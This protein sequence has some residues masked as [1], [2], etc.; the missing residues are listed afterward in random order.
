MTI[1]KISSN[2]FDM[3]RAK[4]YL[5]YHHSNDVAHETEFCN[6][7]PAIGK[8]MLN[9]KKCWIMSGSKIVRSDLSEVYTSVGTVI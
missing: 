9:K 7:K 6:F 1:E 5:H 8:K 3:A 4:Y 2:A